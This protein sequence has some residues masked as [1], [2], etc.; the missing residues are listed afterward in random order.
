MYIVLW[1][2]VELLLK[3]NDINTLGSETFAMFWLFRKSLFSESTN[4]FICDQVIA[5]ETFQN[6]WKFKG[7]LRWKKS[8][9]KWLAFDYVRK[10]MK[11]KTFSKKTQ[12]LL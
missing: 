8:I 10:N 6:H 2:Y 4:S 5:R 9:S 12:K 11:N 1:F 7:E 3:W